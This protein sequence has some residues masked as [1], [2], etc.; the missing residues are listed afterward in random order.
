[1]S[2]HTTEL[3][4]LGQM[5]ADFGERIPG[6]TG[7]VLVTA[8]GLVH[9]YAGIEEIDADRLAA[10]VSGIAA[11]VKGIFQGMPGQVQQ[12]VMEHDG[13]SLFI[14]RADGPEQVRNMVGAVLAVRTNP[15]AD[16]SLVG[17]EM[18]QWIDRMRTHLH[19]PVRSTESPSAPGAPRPVQ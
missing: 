2:Q 10:G 4:V 3:S 9:E 12:T 13:G 15:T 6:V 14:M 18:L 1:M 19:N 11:L 7:S 16:A 8:D 17:Y 5:L